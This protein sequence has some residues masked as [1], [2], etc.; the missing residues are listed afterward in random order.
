MNR[1]PLAFAAV[2]LCAAAP[3]VTVTAPWAR[4]TAPRQTEAAVYLQLT[5]TGDDQLTGI[6]MKE[7]MAMLHQSV[8][9]G[10]MS[11]MRDVESLALP[12]GKT[13]P[14]AP[15]GTHIM[16]MDLTHGLKAGSSVSLMLR[17]AKSAPVQVTAPVL[18]IGSRGP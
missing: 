4:A 8:S 5:S 10:G 18:P 9:H 15:G 2:L 3:S 14:L 13:I 16:L 6:E 11:D 1:W 7:G 17:F 12:A